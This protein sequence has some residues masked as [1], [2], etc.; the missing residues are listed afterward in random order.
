M[1][2]LN[3]ARPSYWAAL[4]LFVLA[5]VA[6]SGCAYLRDNPT[7]SGLA[8]QIATMKVIEA[9]KGHEAERAARIKEIAAE[10]KT[11]LDAKDVTV[12]VLEDAVNARLASLDLAPSDRLLASAL[13]SA[14]VG[15]L[16]V[17]VGDG[18]L[19]ADSRYTVSQILGYVESAAGL[20]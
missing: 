7:T 6:L 4:V 19:S 10:A 18:L 17:K 1:A 20:Y 9:D 2:I 13:V 15:E 16:K 8:V 11:F 3:A 12:S 14:V 5:M